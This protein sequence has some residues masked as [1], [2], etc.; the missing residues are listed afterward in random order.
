MAFLRD[1]RDCPSLIIDVRGNGGGATSSW[2][3]YPVSPLRQDE[4]PVIWTYYELAR[5]SV[6]DNP[7]AGCGLT[8]VS[9]GFLG[10]DLSAGR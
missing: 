3:N 10:Q 2:M 8:P 1:V 4:D 7:A 9:R 5:G 6:Q